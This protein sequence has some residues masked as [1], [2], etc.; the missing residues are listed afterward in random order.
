[1]VHLT[2]AGISE[3]GR[4]LLLLDGDGAEFSLDVDDRLR[5]ALRGETSRLGQLEKRM[6]SALRP[7]DIQAR[8]RAGETAEA[9]AEAAGTTVE[10]I[11]PFAGP[12]L[13][14]RQHVAERAQTSS[15]RRR[16]GDAQAA[17]RTL[18]E[19]V[20]IHLRRHN[21]DP[22]GVS[23][24]AWR[25]EDG[26]WSLTAEFTS[27]KRSG[28]ARLTLDLPGNYVVLDNDDARWL[29]GEL[30]ETAPPA[31]TRDDL[32]EARAR[33]LGQPRDLDP[34]GADADDPP[35]LD[36]PG[37]G[38]PGDAAPVRGSQAPT[39]DA[40]FL[41]AEPDAR[42]AAPATPAA[43]AATAGTSAGDSPA[44]D[45]SDQSEEPGAAA[46]ERRA[47]VGES[48]PAEP[49]RRPARKS[50]GRASVPSWDEIMFGGGGGRGD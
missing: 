30:V 27:L 18:G 32:Q 8:I 49:A 13:A 1:M 46:D 19:A 2:L 28:V 29:V 45:L 24:D 14:E 4:R 12:V 26:R 42:P 37:L 39:G 38:V 10:K 31:P 35:A 7:R 40:G 23:W 47:A 43:P 41:G 15:L 34:V 17:P 20:E 33:R 6:D 48:E 36:L 16:G 9:V 22:A 25:R 44:A 50:R 3:D 11:M 21:V 5:A